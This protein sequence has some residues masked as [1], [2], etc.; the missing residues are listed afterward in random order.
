[1]TGIFVLTE[2]RQGQIRD[3]TFEMLTKGR[4]LAEKANTELT[5]LLFGKNVK[6]HARTLS[7]YA[8]KV[9]LVED[10]KLENFNSK[11]YQNV[12]SWLIKE[13]KPLI[14]LIDKLP[15]A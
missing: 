4:E 15:L 12:L 7:E 13:Y 9:L 5:A 3:I 11:A 8:K 6:K 14:T 2:H 10:S 1:M